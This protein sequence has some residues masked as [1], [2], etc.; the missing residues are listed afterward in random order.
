MSSV[1]SQSRFGDVG[2]RLDMDDAGADDE[3]VEAAE[4]VRGR[5]PDRRADVVG[6]ADVGTER[7]ER[8]AELGVGG[9]KGASETSTAATCAPAAMSRRAISSPKPDAP[10]VM[11]AL[12]PG[13]M[14]TCALSVVEAAS[15]LAVER[16]DA[17]QHATVGGAVRGV[18][19]LDRSGAELGRGVVGRGAAQR[20]VHDRVDRADAV[21]QAGVRLER[22]A[23]VVVLAAVAPEQVLAEVEVEHAAVTDDA[24]LDRMAVV[25]AA[26]VG[27]GTRHRADGAVR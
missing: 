14:P 8:V 4:R 21:V 11:S 18:E 16:R 27:G 7:Q 13:A 5:C 20:R 23:G 9:C 10:P 19:D 26:E 12:R 2:E 6:L 24:D 15:G 25:R 1:V 17:L 3:R 22:H